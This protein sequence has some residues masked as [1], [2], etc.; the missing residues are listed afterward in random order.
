MV[1]K[2]YFPPTRLTE[3]FVER[4]PRAP[5]EPSK[6][7]K[8]LSY[9][10]WD[11]ALKGLFILVGEANL[12]VLRTTGSHAAAA[13]AATPWAA[14]KKGGHMTWF[15]LR[16]KDPEFAAACEEA[17]QHALGAL[18]RAAYDRALKGWKRPV[19]QQGQL[20]GHD[21]VVDNGL[22]LRVLSR[23]DPSWSPNRNVTVEGSIDHNHQH[24]HIAAIGVADLMHLAEDERELLLGL[25]EKIADGRGEPKQIAAEPTVPALPFLGDEAEDAEF[26]EV[27]E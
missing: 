17:L 23:L 14:S 13:R 9:A 16:K 27:D 7:N 1:A 12:E 19:Y 3:R 26:V 25:L 15:D 4:L 10:V 2:P 11:T 8:I 5:R 6:R 18:E 21:L 24:N 22:L 20:V